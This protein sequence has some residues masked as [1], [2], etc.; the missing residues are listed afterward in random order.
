M[1]CRHRLEHD[2]DSYEYDQD[3]CIFWGI[4]RLTA[5]KKRGAFVFSYSPQT[6]TFTHEHFSLYKVLSGGP[7][8]FPRQPAE[9]GK[10]D[11]LRGGQIKTGMY[12]AGKQ[13]SRVGD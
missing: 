1:K 6:C 7:L 8:Q 13:D 5:S 3:Y 11:L 2:L 4:S 9:R 10:E 12:V